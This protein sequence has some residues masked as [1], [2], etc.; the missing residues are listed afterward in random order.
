MSIW[1]T[2]KKFFLWLKSILEKIQ[3][4]SD[5]TEEPSKPVEPPQ[6]KS[7]KKGFWIWWEKALHPSYFEKAVAAKTGRIYLKIWD[8]ASAVSFWREQTEKI[9]MYR[10]A[11]IDVWGWGYHF[12]SGALPNHVQ[13]I[14]RI[15]EAQ[16]LGMT[17]YVFD[18]EA[19]LKGNETLTLA[20]EKLI[21]EVKKSVVKPLTLGISTFDQVDLHPTFPYRLWKLVDCMLPQCYENLRGVKSAEEY[22]QRINEAIQKHR[23]IGVTCPIYPVIG[24]EPGAANNLDKEGAQ[25]VLDAFE[26]ASLYR[27]HEANEQ[28][29]TCL[30]VNY[31]GDPKMPPVTQPPTNPPATSIQQK[32][33]KMADIAEVEGKKKLTW[34]QTSEAE[35]YLATVRKALGMPTGR[36]AWCG[37][38][39]TWCAQQADVPVPVIFPTGYTSAYVPGWEKWAKAKGYWYSESL[40]KDKFNPRRGDIVL[41][42]WDRDVTPDHIG[43]VLNYDGQRTIIAAEGNTSASNNSN[44]NATAVRTR[45]WSTIRGFI[46]LS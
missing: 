31:G 43:I 22:I 32:L 28:I 4:P 1:E 39:V 34:T 12:T 35:K 9:K 18:L 26:F 42:D 3:V 25:K 5:D 30:Q 23:E 10:E 46:R 29:T 36:F 27:I 41:Y 13:V 2:V 21:N 20:A 40:P 44:G 7:S 8:D 38:F 15:K 16:D 14:A 37:A 11:G 33:I 24:V 45:D 17:G 19:E 6:D